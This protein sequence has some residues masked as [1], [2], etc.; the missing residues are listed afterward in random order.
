VEEGEAAV[1]SVASLRLELEKLK[2]ENATFKDD[3][4]KVFTHTAQGMHPTSTCC[5]R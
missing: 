3:A 1:H 5:T 2:K 4:I